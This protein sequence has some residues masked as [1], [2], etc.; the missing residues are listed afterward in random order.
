MDR[1]SVRKQ[2]HPE[3]PISGLRNPSPTPDPLICLDMLVLRV[4]YDP[5]NPVVLD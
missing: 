4:F 5:P 3:V 1:L 2:N